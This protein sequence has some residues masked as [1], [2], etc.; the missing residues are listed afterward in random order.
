M[1][2]LTDGALLALT[3]ESLPAIKRALREQFPEAKSSHRIEAFARTVG[4]GTY[5]SML[6]R[7]DALQPGAVFETSYSADQFRGWI[8]RLEERHDAAL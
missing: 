4:F 1:T 6:A 7:L 8:D 5:N 2:P 3:Y